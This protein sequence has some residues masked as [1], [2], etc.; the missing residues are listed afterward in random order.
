MLIHTFFSFH[1]KVFEKKEKKQTFNSHFQLVRNMQKNIDRNHLIGQIN[2]LESLIK[3]KSDSK[4]VFDQYPILIRSQLHFQAPFVLRCNPFLFGS[5]VVMVK[6]MIHIECQGQVNILL[7]LIL[8]LRQV[9]HRH[10][11]RRFSFVF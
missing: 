11:W 5:I 2:V 9:Y 3:K 6:L 4:N 1:F 10:A 7:E 8:I